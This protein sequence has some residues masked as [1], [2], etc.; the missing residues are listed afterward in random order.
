MASFKFEVKS[1]CAVKIMSQNGA[2]VGMRLLLSE[3]ADRWRLGDVVIFPG[4]DEG[5]DDFLQGGLLI[6]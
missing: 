1:K 2:S 3:L 4:D 5:V 6:W